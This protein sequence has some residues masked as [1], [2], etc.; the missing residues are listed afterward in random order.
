MK[1]IILLVVTIGLITT[2]SCSEETTSTD[3]KIQPQTSLA[4][5]V[6]GLR[7]DTIMCKQVPPNTNHIQKLVFLD[8]SLFIRIV[9]TSCSDIG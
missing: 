6:Y 7:F 2:Q 3:T 5:K 1:K 4:G 8:D 9:P